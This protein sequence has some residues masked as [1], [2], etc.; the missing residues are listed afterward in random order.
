VLSKKSVA[1]EYRTGQKERGPGSGKAT[2]S[3]DNSSPLKMSLVPLASVRN[4]RED[5]A[6]SPAGTIGFCR[7]S[8]ASRD[9]KGPRGKVEHQ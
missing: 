3:Q 1:T 9:E 2:R 7:G 4:T 6:S 5:A 8:K